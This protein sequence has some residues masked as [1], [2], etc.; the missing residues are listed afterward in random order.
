MSDQLAKGSVSWES[1]HAYRL[2]FTYDVPG[3]TITLDVFENGVQKQS[4]SGDAHHF[5]LRND[6][7]PL[8]VDFGMIGVGG[9]GGYVPPLGWQYSNLKVVLKP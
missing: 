6:G 8:I 7:H 5:D 1:G 3:K 2:R 4:V 9:D